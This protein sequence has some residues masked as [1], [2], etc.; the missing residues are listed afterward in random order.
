MCHS[1]SFDNWFEKQDD[2]GSNYLNRQIEIA[3]LKIAAVQKCSLSI[4]CMGMKC[5]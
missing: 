1:A 5:I 3:S 4:K 2:M